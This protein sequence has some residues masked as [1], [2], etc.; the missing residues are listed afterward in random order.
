MNL[1]T[2][3]SESNGGMVS[4]LGLRAIGP[5]VK[6]HPRQF[7]FFASLLDFFVSMFFWG[8]PIHFSGY[9]SHTLGAYSELHLQALSNGTIGV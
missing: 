6:S 4:M 7:Y 3:V 8:V 2:N 5:E 9:F 1:Q